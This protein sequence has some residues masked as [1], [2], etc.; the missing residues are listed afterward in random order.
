MRSGPAPLPVRAPSYAII[1]EMVPAPWIART[2]RLAKAC[3]DR[4]ARQ[5]GAAV[6]GSLVLVAWSAGAAVRPPVMPDQM[7]PRTAG[8]VLQRA[9]DAKGGLE[10][11]RAIRSVVMR[12]T[13]IVRSPQPIEARTTSYIQ[14]P[15]RFRQDAKLPRGEMTQVYAD[16]AA[17]VK[18]PS[19]IHDVTPQERDR[20][21]RNASRDIVSLLLKAAQGRLDVNLI[22]S[23]EGQPAADTLRLSG[24]DQPPVELMID[25]ASGMVAGERYVVEQPGAI[26]KVPTEELY[27]DYR[28]VDGIRVAFKT[29]VRRGEAVILERTLTDIELDV[30]LDAT[31]F[32]RPV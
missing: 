32:K 25:R 8:A 23:G 11:L 26:G 17:W 15:D 20:L 24:D 22:A 7:Q 21:R 13:V 29:I 27:S 14:Y 9:I 31:L 16:G 5:L 1:A 30:P 3:L 2:T 12:G 6:V 4:C 10:R 28:V 19:G 18:D